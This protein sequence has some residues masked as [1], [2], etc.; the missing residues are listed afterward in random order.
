[1]AR[2]RLASGPQHP[3][4]NPTE[5]DSTPVESI[6]AQLRDTQIVY[7]FLADRMRL[8]LHHDITAWAEQLGADDLADLDRTIRKLQRLRAA[9]VARLEQ[10]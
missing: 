1:M 8:L 3:A 9:L 10:S 6:A 2:G 4:N 7:A 5:V